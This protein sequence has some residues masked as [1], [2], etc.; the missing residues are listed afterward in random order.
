MQLFK[1]KK[2]RGLFT[3]H[4]ALLR[5]PHLPRE[6]V[7]VDFSLP[8]ETQAWG[9]EVMEGLREMPQSQKA[10]PGGVMGLSPAS[11]LGFARSCACASPHYHPRVC[12]G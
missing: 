3:P 10:S 5:R 2:G 4:S 8:K 6:E 12:R 9:P 11:W 1:N 7:M